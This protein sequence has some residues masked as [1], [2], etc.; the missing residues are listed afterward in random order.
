[1]ITPSTLSKYNSIFKLWSGHSSPFWIL[2]GTIV[3]KPVDSDNSLLTSGNKQKRISKNNLIAPGKNKLFCI[4]SCTSEIPSSNVD[5]EF[6]S[7]CTLFESTAA[8]HRIRRLDHYGFTNYWVNVRK[9]ERVYACPLSE[10]F[11]CVM[12]SS[13]K[14]KPQREC[15]L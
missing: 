7:T 15:L 3:F 5:P 8:E 6:W 11:A 4:V 1:M 13:S 9:Y 12:Q 14:V 2:K 10:S